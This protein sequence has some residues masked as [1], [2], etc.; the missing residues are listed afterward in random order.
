MNAPP[1]ALAAAPNGQRRRVLLIV[2]AIFVLIALAA[3]AW[4]RF[5]LSVRET[6]ND[7]YVAGHTVTVS[8]QVPG[9]V[10][11]VL[12]ED[13]QRVRAGDVLVRLDPTDAQTSLQRAS[14]ALAAAVRSARAQ[15]AAASQADALV[16]ARGAELASALATLARREPLAAEHAVSNEELSDARTA[17]Q[18]ARAAL[19]EAEALARGAHAA[20]DGI[21]V[22]D[23]P[24]VLQAR[25]AFREAWIN[26][27]RNSIV[28]PLDGRVA[29][30]TAQVGRRV[31]AGEPLLRIVAEDQLWVDANFKE[32]QLRNLKIGQAV[33]VTVDAWGGGVVYH[34]RVAGVSAGT[35]AA[36]ALLPPQ[37]ASGNW[38]K[39]IQ[40]VPV[41]IALDHRELVEHPLRI[42]LSTEVNVDTATPPGA[43]PV[44]AT[45]G[46]G[47][48]AL[49]TERVEAE[50][51]AIIAANLR[52]TT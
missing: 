47:V 48:Y 42:G 50:A 1:E 26:A 37:N 32:T 29:Q 21:Q 6:T 13:T 46:T 7:A 30:R 12:A 2:T 23:N 22:R 36:F 5:V 43:A 49:D 33:R 19:N 4:W 52:G 41:R 34:G 3:L 25:A 18:R 24:A 10:V 38:I 17:V 40:R 28:A 20:V 45:A 9:T 14:G 27:H 8:A 51:E 16:A 39:V 11:E 15:S 35:G 44:L 31:Q